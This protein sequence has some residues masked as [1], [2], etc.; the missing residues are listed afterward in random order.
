MMCEVGLD[1]VGVATQD[2]VELPVLLVDVVPH[3]TTKQIVSEGQRW[4][5]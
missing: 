3:T 1:L 5:C 2:G 4:V